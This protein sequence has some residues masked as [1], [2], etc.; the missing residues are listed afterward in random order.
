MPARAQ[1]PRREEMLAQKSIRAL[2]AMAISAAVLSPAAPASAGTRADADWTEE[3]FPSSDGLTTLHADVL[4][5][6]GL[7]SDVR[8][9]VILTVTPYTNHAGGPI[10]SVNPYDPVGLSGPS[11]RFYDFLD[12]SGALT[13]GYTYVMVDLPG[14]G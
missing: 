3:Y 2:I 12:L 7:G 11:P 13:K 9:P 1:T 10:G 6:K 8:T 4:R 14:T 5:P